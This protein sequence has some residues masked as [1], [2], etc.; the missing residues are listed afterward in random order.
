MIMKLFS[1]IKAGFIDFIK[2]YDRIQR[3]NA[4]AILEW[5]AGELQNIFGLILFGFIVGFP[6]APMH[7]TLDLLPH[8]GD[9]LGILLEKVDTANEPIAE[10]FSLLDIG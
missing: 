7:I 6:S 10:L 5:E 2:G 3:M 9:E 1:N 8:I 4:S